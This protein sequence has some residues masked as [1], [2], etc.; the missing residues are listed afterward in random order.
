MGRPHVKE[1]SPKDAIPQV[2]QE[3]IQ[4]VQKMNVVRMILEGRYAFTYL[5][6][7][8]RWDHLFAASYGLIVVLVL[9]V[10]NDKI[11]FDY[12]IIMNK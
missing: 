9:H 10:T 3:H 7:V 5:V 1:S 4:P 11:S 2:A 8:Q 12:I 6:F